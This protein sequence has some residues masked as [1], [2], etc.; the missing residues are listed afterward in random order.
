MAI[1]ACPDCGQQ[2]STMAAAC[3]HCGYPLQGPPKVV[4]P[5]PPPA[6][7]A[8]TVKEAKRTA[9][10]LG[11]VIALILVLWAVGSIS[12]CQR[13]TSP[14]SAA[15]TPSTASQSTYTN[16]DLGA[17]ITLMQD[18]EEAAG[19]RLS[20]AKA[21]IQYFPN[22]SEAVVAKGLLGK[23]EIAANKAASNPPGAWYYRSE[24]DPMTS[25]K[26]LTATVS[27]ESPFALDFPYQGAQ[28]AR[29]TLRRHP[30]WGKDVIFQIERG[31]LTCDVYECPLRVRFGDGE[32]VT[33]RAARAEDHSSEVAFIQEYD[34]FLKRMRAVD[35]IKIQFSVYRGGTIVQ[36]FN[37]RGFDN[38]KLQ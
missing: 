28:N 21:I 9:G 23:L 31:Q 22:S 5:T 25:K 38:K 12:Q 8:A 18:E 29:I 17:W 20:R 26:V 6:P 10:C 24:T 30:K 14:K 11:P 27:S 32:T 3:P 4:A 35:S 1:I 15:A 13:E 7:A 36:E 16:Q 37:V 2:V 19:V 34:S 33:Y